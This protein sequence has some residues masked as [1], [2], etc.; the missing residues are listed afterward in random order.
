MPRRADEG[1]DEVQIHDIVI[2]PAVVAD[3]TATT[4]RACIDDRLGRDLLRPS[5]GRRL[6][7]VLSS[8]SAKACKAVGKRIERQVRSD[9]SVLVIHSFCMMH[10]FWAGIHNVL[11][12]FNLINAVFCCS[13]LAHK[14]RY[15]RT[16]RKHLKAQLPL[17]LEASFQPPD[18]V[19]KDPSQIAQTTGK[20]LRQ[21]P[22]SEGLLAFRFPLKLDLSWAVALS[23]VGVGRVLAVRPWRFGGARL[24]RKFCL[25]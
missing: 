8:D 20:Y 18:A 2:P 17:L 25:R 21:G 6:G 1:P 13:I 7:L 22:V 15:V 23:W 16:V 19:D 24:L 11:N 3:T 4:L 9:P 5:K 12:K 10:T 14:A